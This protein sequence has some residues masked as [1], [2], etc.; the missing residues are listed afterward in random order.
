[1]EAMAAFY[2]RLG[3]PMAAGH[4]EWA[5]GQ[6]EWA[7]NHRSA[8]SDDAPTIELDSVE[9]TSWWKQGWRAGNGIVLAFEVPD[10]ADVDRL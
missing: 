5:T 9:F 3:L 7:A 2:E 10:R 8:R 1:M 4:P 6:P